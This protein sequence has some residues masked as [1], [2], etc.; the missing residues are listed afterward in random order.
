MKLPGLTPGV[1]SYPN[2]FIVLEFTLG[3]YA[4]QQYA[5]ISPLTKQRAY[6]LCVVNTNLLNLRLA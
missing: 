3:V 2:N 6:Y 4:E 5:K 1:P